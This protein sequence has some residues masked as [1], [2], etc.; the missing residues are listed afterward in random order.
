V[1]HY[2]TVHI[3][4]RAR[5]TR[6]T[7]SCT[8]YAICIDDTGYRTDGARRAG[9]S[10]APVHEPVHAETL[11]VRSSCSSLRNITEGA[12]S[13]PRARPEIMEPRSYRPEHL[14]GTAT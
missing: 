12:L 1:E 13:T 10:G 9:L 11:L 7:A 2:K 6:S 8:T 5:V 4:R 3:L 14:A